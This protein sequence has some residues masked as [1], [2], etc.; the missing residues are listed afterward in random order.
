MRS[1]AEGSPV[2]NTQKMRNESLSECGYLYR[3]LTKSQENSPKS[4]QKTKNNNL[5]KTKRI[6]NIEIQAKR[7]PA[8]T[9]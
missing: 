5:L 2:T 7:C 9:F 4:F 6:L 3:T 8:F 1:V